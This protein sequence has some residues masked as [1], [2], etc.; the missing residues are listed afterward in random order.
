M[1]VVDRK[2]LLESLR[3]QKIEVSSLSPIFEKWP[4]HR[5]PHW[6]ALIPEVNGKLE[7]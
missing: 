5:N 1:T 6:K 2:I 4:A 3:G 7:R